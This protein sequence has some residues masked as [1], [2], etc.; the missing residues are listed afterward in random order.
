MQYFENSFNLVLL[1]KTGILL[2]C[3]KWNDETPYCVV[4]YADLKCEKMKMFKNSN[5]K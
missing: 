5:S 1:F 3:K 4:R 2:Y